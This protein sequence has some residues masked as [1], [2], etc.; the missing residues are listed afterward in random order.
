M[1]A[2]R[3]G[4]AAYPNLKEADPAIQCQLQLPRSASSSLRRVR[5]KE[6]WMMLGQTLFV[7]DTKIDNFKKKHTG[8]TVCDSYQPDRKDVTDHSSRFQLILSDEG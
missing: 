3:C 7:Q 6:Q 8:I 1:I 2:F 4:G 5:G